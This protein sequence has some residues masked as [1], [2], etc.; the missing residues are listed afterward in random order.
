MELYFDEYIYFVL[1]YLTSIRLWIQE[2]LHKG[3]E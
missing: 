2:Q 3:M 1:N